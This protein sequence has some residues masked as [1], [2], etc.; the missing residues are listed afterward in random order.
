MAGES[1]G[2][3]FTRV[4]PRGP[5][6]QTKSPASDGAEFARPGQWRGD[7]LI[8]VGKTRSCDLN[9]SVCLLCDTAARR[10]ASGWLPTLDAEPNQPGV[11]DADLNPW[12]G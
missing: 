7:H 8:G 4:T 5:T 9:V 2:A 12:A 3:L 10:E 11:Q 6:L 1:G